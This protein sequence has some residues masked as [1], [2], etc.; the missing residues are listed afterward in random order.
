MS[1]YTHA[2]AILSRKELPAA[3][4]ARWERRSMA[5]NV[6]TSLCLEL[7]ERSVPAVEEVCYALSHHF[8]LE[9]FIYT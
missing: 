8:I 4:E 3:A 6:R 7:A 1:N 2:R 9:T 5:E